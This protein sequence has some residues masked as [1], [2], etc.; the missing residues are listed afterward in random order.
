MAVT[1]HALG[2]DGLGALVERCCATA[3]EVAKRVEAHPGLRLWGAPE[4]STVVLRPVVADETGDDELVARVRRALLEAGTAVI[5]RAALPTGPGGTDQL[6]LKLTLLHPHTTAGDYLPLLDRI[7]AT[8][9]AELVAS[10]ESPV[11]S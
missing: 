5:G 1:V 2:T 6:W 4:L 10:R 3:A 9:G 8:A 11:A 7:A